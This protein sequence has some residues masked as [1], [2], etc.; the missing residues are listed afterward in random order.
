MTNTSQ[1]QQL[2]NDTASISEE[3]RTKQVR[4]AVTKRIKELGRAKKVQVHQEL[5]RGCQ[6][7]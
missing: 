1:A 5:D 7:I 4:I 3:K 6:A 2:A